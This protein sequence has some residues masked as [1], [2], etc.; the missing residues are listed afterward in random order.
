M[1]KDRLDVSE[2][3]AN[4]YRAGPFFGA[5][6]TELDELFPAELGGFQ[7]P[8]AQCKKIQACGFRPAE[9]SPDVRQIRSVK[10]NEVSECLGRGNASVYRFPPIDLALNGPRPKLRVTA[11]QEGFTDVVPFTSDLDSPGARRKL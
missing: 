5:L 4:R 2:V 6:T 8:E 9:R 11:A 1:R 10:I 7:R 3:D